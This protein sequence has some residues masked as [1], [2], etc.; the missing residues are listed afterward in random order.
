LGF[1]GKLVRRLVQQLLTAGAKQ[2]FGF[3]IALYE[4]GFV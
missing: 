3:L 2:L 4:A 1:G